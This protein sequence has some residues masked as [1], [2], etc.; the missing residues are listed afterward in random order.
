MDNYGDSEQGY[1]EKEV[2]SDFVCVK[3]ILE[4]KP[5]CWCQVQ[6]LRWICGNRRICP[7][8]SHEQSTRLT[9]SW[10]H[11]TIAGIIMRILI[12][13]RE[14]WINFRG[15]GKGTSSIVPLRPVDEWWPREGVPIEWI[16]SKVHFPYFDRMRRQFF[17]QLLGIGILPPT[18]TLIAN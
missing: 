17:C 11:S 6:R 15:S 2:T 12:M 10:A 18:T 16:I 8:P 14:P 13:V 4:Y 1:T 9:R 7:S 3:D 5:R